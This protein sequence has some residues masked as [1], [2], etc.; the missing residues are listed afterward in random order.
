MQKR[1]CIGLWVSCGAALS[2]GDVTGFMEV[3]D[4]P[5]ATSWARETLTGPGRPRDTIYCRETKQDRERTG[6]Q[7]MA[8]APGRPRRPRR[9]LPRLRHKTLPPVKVRIPLPSCFVNSGLCRVSSKARR[10]PGQ[11]RLEYLASRP[12]ASAVWVQTFFLKE[13]NVTSM[14]FQ[15]LRC[16]R[17]PPAPFA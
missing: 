6:R 16:H 8:A 2:T 14:V 15:E 1:T 3:G 13:E 17:H 5:R 7:E 10:S 4:E 11:H 12:V 9:A